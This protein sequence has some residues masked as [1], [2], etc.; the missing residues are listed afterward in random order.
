MTHDYKNCKFNIWA[1]GHLNKPNFFV[2]KFE[3]LA[4]GILLTGAECPLKRD[5]SPNIRK[6][7]KSTETKLV[8]PFTGEEQ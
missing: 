2:W 7:D 1:R 8:M 3:R 6:R 5:G 4:N